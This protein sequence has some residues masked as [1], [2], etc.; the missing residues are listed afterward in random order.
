[1]NDLRVNDLFAM[2]PFDDM[3][4]GLMR[5]W[6]AELGERVP[7]IKLDLHETDADYVVKADVP[8]VKKEDI[9]VRIDGDKVTISAE[10]KKQTEEKK[11][12]RLLRAERQTG[13]AQRSFTLPCLVDEARAVARY[14]N[15]VLE[16]TLPKKATTASKRLPID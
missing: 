9:D 10:V 12:G 8:G 15:G 1:M 2:E 11:D 13:F 14:Q 3:F 6:R 16:L 5:P 4:R 7:Q